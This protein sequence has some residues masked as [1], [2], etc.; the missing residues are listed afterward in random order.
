MRVLK[1]DSFRFVRLRF[2][3]RFESP[4]HPPHY[5]G[6]TLRGGFGRSLREIVCL[7]PAQS[8]SSC[9]VKGRCPYL[10][11][12]ETPRPEGITPSYSLSQCPHPF[13]IEPPLDMP[14]E[15]RPG[16]EMTFDLLLIGRAIG[17]LSLVIAA[18]ELL[19]GMGLGRERARYR[20]EEV[21]SPSNGELIYV[22]GSK[23]SIPTAMTLADLMEEAGKTDDDRRLT[24]LFLTP[25]RIRY[26]GRLISELSFQV[27]MRN[28]LRRIL[29]LSELHCDERLELDPL[30]ALREAERARTI[31]SELNWRD[32]QRFSFR[33]RSKM[34]LGGFVGKVSF[35]GVSGSL[36][37]LIKLGE[38]VHIGKGTSFGLGKYKI[39]GGERGDG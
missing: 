11:I 27:F 13:V 18:Y 24:L 25:T 19:G 29:I 35:E 4:F 16:D 38:Y 15:Y 14:P 30:A 7:D 36:F 17:H 3:V 28:L 12:F 21:I 20:L 31:C 33:Q 9:L 32:W 5:L 10:Y 22:P 1:A 37:P 8:C 2:R 39:L 34:K 26:R 23:P 6:S